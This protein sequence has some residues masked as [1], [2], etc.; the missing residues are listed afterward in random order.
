MAENYPAMPASHVP[1][2]RGKRF[3]GKCFLAGNPAPL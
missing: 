2:Y 1:L 3:G